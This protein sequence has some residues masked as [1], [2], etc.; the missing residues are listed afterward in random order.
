MNTVPPEELITPEAVKQRLGIRSDRSFWA[1][2]HRSNLPHYR[3][4]AR[5]IRF[6]LSEVEAWL[7]R[8]RKGAV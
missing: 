6:R 7:E 3:L 8:Q 2:L 5:V 1:M 4:N